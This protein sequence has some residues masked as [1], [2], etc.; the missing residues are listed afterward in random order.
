MVVLGAY[1]PRHL[2]GAQS[3][4]GAVKG[5]LRKLLDVCFCG[6]IIDN[7]VVCGMLNLGGFEA[8]DEILGISEGVVACRV[9]ALPDDLIDGAVFA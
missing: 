3:A 2:V 9:K 7:G 4:L 5:L 6:V 8:I 1:S